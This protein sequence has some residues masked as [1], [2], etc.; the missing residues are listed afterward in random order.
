MC[1]PSYLPVIEMQF[2][3]GWKDDG[4]YDTAVLTCNRFGKTLNGK[5]T[6]KMHTHITAGINY[7]SLGVVT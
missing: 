2:R 5:C 7:L 3:L 6:H 1:Q 4:C